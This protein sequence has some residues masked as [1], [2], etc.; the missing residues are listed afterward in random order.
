MKTDHYNLIVVKE[1][2]PVGKVACLG[3]VS[4]IISLL[5][6]LEKLLLHEALLYSPTTH[7]ASNCKI[8]RVPKYGRGDEDSQKVHHVE[9]SQPLTRVRK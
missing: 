3:K 9:L 2:I 8:H 7:F 6:L 4:K 5:C 1:G